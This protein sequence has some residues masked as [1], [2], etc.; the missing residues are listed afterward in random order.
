MRSLDKRK[1]E[2]FE[3]TQ[4]AFIECTEAQYRLGVCKN[5]Y[6]ILR[7]A[8]QLK[9]FKQESIDV[10]SE[11]REAHEREITERIRE[12]QVLEQQNDAL[13]VDHDRQREEVG[14]PRSRTQRH[15]IWD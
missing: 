1:N 15:A 6:G 2:A 14:Q 11:Q 8:M 7:D 9:E 3:E 10:A 12:Y 13:Q 4:A 5:A